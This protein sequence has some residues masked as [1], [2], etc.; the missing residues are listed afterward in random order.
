M[1]FRKLQVPSPESGNKSNRVEIEIRRHTPDFA[2]TY[3]ML[4]Q[5]QRE[6]AARVRNGGEGALLLSEVAPVITLGRRTRPADVWLT[7]ETLAAR[8][9]DL[10]SVNRGG[11]ATYH[12][13]GQWLVFVID[14]LE[15][16][17]GDRRGVRRAVEGLLSVGL[18]VAQEYQPTAEIR[19]GA[20]TGVWGLNGKLVAVGVHVEQGILLHGLAFNVFATEQSFQG[21]RPC[22]LDAPPGF[23]EP[24]SNT[25]LFESV[26]K[27]LIQAGQ[28]RF[29]HRERK[30]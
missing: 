15:R 28:E 3:A 14:S 13:P 7:A 20:E 18:Q 16:L 30:A 29:W 8:G 6:I 22:G 12:G 21:I 19:E 17:T 24:R 10:L 25:A 27:S 11:L 9:I 23:L 1:S 2:W 26:G 4:D 5:R